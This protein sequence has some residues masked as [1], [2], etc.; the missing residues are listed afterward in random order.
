MEQ[1]AT[2]FKSMLRHPLQTGS[3]I[4]SSRYLAQ[5]M[6]RDMDLKNASCV[7]ELG[8]GT[9]AFTRTIL[10]QLNPQAVFF[11]LEWNPNLVTFLKRE[12]PNAE[13]HCDSAEHL[14]KYLAERNTKADYILSGLPLSW[15]PKDL[16]ERV[17]DTVHE[18]LTDNG[19]FSMFQYIHSSMTPMGAQVHH[20]LK[21]RFRS[22]KIS[23]TLRNL[24]PALV[25]TC[26]K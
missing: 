26:E 13:I 4:P 2:F 8:P 25:L 11:A 14:G 18:S 9:G 20:M 21:K 23:R 6:V 22:I 3:V 17:L 15:L 7:V 12:F 19:K 10:S 24:P 5:T 1:Y 16:G